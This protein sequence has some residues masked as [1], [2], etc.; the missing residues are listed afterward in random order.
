[1]L[2]MPATSAMMP[3]AFFIVYLPLKSTATQPLHSRFS[4]NPNLECFLIAL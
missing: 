2:K 4:K 1:M 3:P